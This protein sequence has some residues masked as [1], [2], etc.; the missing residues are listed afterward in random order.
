V[1]AW[2]PWPRGLRSRL[3]LAFVLTTV[4]GA[5]AAA[6]ASAGSA[7]ASL[8]DAAQQRLTETVTDQIGALTP[9]LTYPPDQDTLDRLRSAV[10]TNTLVTYG[11]LRAEDG[12][13]SRLVTGAL[14]TEVRL[15]HQLVTQRLT[16]DG[17]PWLVIGTRS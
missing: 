1:T 7:S 3:L 15:R 4:L 16:V 6:A 8:A 10:G 2:R 9:Q 17:G 13:G 12:N 5:A 14:R 11:T